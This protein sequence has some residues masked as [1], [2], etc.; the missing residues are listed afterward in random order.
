MEETRF[1]SQAKGQSTQSVARSNRSAVGRAGEDAA[2]DHLRQLGYALL[3]RNWRC[4]LG[5]I[6]IIAM[7]GSALI[8]IEVRSRTNPTRFGTAVEAVTP[9][10]CRQVREVATVYLKQ[11][12]GVPQSIRFDVIAV[13]FLQGG[14]DP[15]IKHLQGAF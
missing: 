15:E 5:E 14:A 12:G 11:H 7:D 10:K 6:D 9:R 4:R 13:T 1:Q 3:E 8:I 2:A